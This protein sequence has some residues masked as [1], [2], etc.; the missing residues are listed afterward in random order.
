MTILGCVLTFALSAQ[1]QFIK[2]YQHPENGIQ[3]G[4]I[5]YLEDRDELLFYGGV[6]TCNLTE[7]SHV[8]RLSATG[9]VLS[10]EDLCGMD[11]SFGNA[12]RRNDTLLYAFHNAPSKSHFNLYLSDAD[13]GDS[14][15]VIQLPIDSSYTRQLV[16]E[17]KYY[18][19]KYYLGGRGF[20]EGEGM[21]P[22][23][24]VLNQDFSV[25]TLLTLPAYQDTR[26]MDL[27]MMADSTLLLLYSYKDDRNDHFWTIA[28]Y[29]QNLNRYL[30]QIRESNGS[31]AD[32]SVRFEYMGGHDIVYC[33][34]P[35]LS[36][37]ADQV[38]ERLDLST[39]TMRWRLPIVIRSTSYVKKLNMNGITKL[40]TG[41][42]LI[43]G[44]YFDSSDYP[45][46]ADNN[47]PYLAKLDGDTGEIIWER[48]IRQD[49][50]ETSRLWDHWHGAVR[51]A[52]QLPDGDIALTGSLAGTMGNRMIMA[53]LD[54]TGCLTPDCDRIIDLDELVLNDDVPTNNDQLAVLYPNPLSGDQL[55][56]NITSSGDYL[57]S[58]YDLSGRLLLHTGIHDSGEVLLDR[59][60][61]GVYVVKITDT[62]NKYYTTERLIKI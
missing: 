44:E 58:I 31:I 9:Q 46:E 30:E 49:L 38:V 15:T 1:D 5:I 7:S 45:N 41:D 50:E 11:S 26:I 4:D 52:Y 53:R 3:G 13:T 14:L 57:L 42:V 43:Y 54:S 61:S 34:T 59:L 21:I 28:G 35:E 27:K 51:Y 18:H 19:G 23:L 24:Y 22:L 32:G 6:Y 60:E 62:D 10:S 29:D 25:D 47:S 33:Y 16:H 2:T 37:A 55:S 39:G 12:I 48:V 56:Y 36:G 8:V 17:L 20:I 40:P